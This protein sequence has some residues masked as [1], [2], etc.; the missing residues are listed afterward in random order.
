[1]AN[2]AVICAGL[3][4]VM[5]A[6]TLEQRGFSTTVFD[7]GRRVGGRCSSRDR[8]QPYDHGAQF[9][10][11]TD[12]HFES[13]I[14]ALREA[15]AVKPWKGHFVTLQAG[16]EGPTEEP[17]RFVGVPNMRAIVENLAAELTVQNDNHIKRIEMCARGWRLINSDE[18]DLGEYDAVVLAMA[19][20][21]VRS[22][23]PSESAIFSATTTI[24]SQACWALMM[25]FAERLPLPYD[26]ASIDHDI[27]KWVAR[28]S[29]KP[30]RPDGERWVAH[31]TASW[32]EANV[33]TAP[34]IAATVLHTEF[35]DALQLPK[36]ALINATAHR[37]RLG[38]PKGASSKTAH[39]DDDLQI[40]VCGDWCVD[41]RLEGAYL[42]GIT[43][44][45]LIACAIGSDANADPLAGKTE[46]RA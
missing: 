28:D 34:D 25:E 22:L 27:I 9:L 14:N 8:D 40:G 11:I 23:L 30:G 13:A 26:S 5:A 17:V 46:T 31:S 15:G 18:S 4:G 12:A 19:P 32:A 16:T 24:K 29:S 41:G 33:R 36:T 2:I 35:L 1:M 21:Q 6:R 45:E 10:T 44:G 39:W 3:A 38:F 42:S 43:C 7:R 20:E 37:W